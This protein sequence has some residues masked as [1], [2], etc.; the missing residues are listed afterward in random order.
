MPGTDGQSC[1]DFIKDH[2]RNIKD[3]MIIHDGLAS[4]R[5]KRVIGQWNQKGASTQ[6][7]PPSSCALS[8][9]ETVFAIVKGRFRKWL[10]EDP[11]VVTQARAE[12]KILQLFGKIGKSQCRKIYKSILPICHQVMMGHPV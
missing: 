4:N 10:A 3:F 2:V 5:M 8:S 6:M 7:T 1:F 11:K 9:V 12:S